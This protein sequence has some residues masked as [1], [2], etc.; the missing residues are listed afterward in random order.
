M[1]IVFTPPVTLASIHSLTF[2]F[3]QTDFM[4]KSIVVILIFGSILAW[5]VMVAK[6]AELKRSTLMSRRFLAA[7]RKQPH[8][9]ALYRPHQRGADNPIEGIYRTMCDGLAETAATR[10]IDV[11]EYVRFP[12]RKIELTDLQI[13]SLRKAAE[14]GVTDQAMLMESGMAVLATATTAAPF[15]GLL[16]TVWGVLD[17]F[18]AMSTFGSA[19]LSA[20]APGISGALL[21][22]VAGLFV[23]L[24]SAIG[25]NMLV[26]RIKLLCVQMDNFADELIDDI[27]SRTERTR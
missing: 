5:S 11:A 24:P 27:L 23:A 8:P 2:S 12:E 18:C 22:T 10:G 14:R 9:L 3:Q 6:F 19:M 21:T 7:Y 13:D 25:Y 15:L 26:S 1:N 4:G 17:A 20:V 16:G